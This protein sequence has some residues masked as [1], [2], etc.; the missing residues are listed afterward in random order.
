MKF[1]VHF[2]DVKKLLSF[3]LGEEVPSFP[4]GEEVL[5]PLSGDE[6]RGPFLKRRAPGGAPC[7]AG[8]ALNKPSQRVWAL[9]SRD[10]FRCTAAIHPAVLHEQCLPFEALTR[11]CRSG[12]KA[13]VRQR[14]YGEGVFLAIGGEKGREPDTPAV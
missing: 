13:A 6:G 14:R 9:P 11:A 3:P 7:A 5:S 4:S 10:V 2:L 1:H 8:F 12:L